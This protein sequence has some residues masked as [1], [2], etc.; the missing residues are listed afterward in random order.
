MPRRE[1]WKKKKEG[2]KKEV[3]FYHS[4]SFTPCVSTSSFQKD[5]LADCVLQIFV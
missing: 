5:Q 4:Y 1:K 3:V 2:E